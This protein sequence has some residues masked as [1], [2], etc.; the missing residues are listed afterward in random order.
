MWYAVVLHFLMPNTEQSSSTNAEVKFAP[1]SLSSLAGMPNTESHMCWLV[2]QCQVDSSILLHL[3]FQSVVPRLTG[4]APE[5]YVAMFR[6][7]ILGD[8]CHHI[9]C[10]VICEDQDIF[11]AWWL[12]QLHGCLYV[13]EV[14][15]NQF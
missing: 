15:M 13:G 7:L 11:D 1:Q 10:E 9:S 4:F 12:I 6:F 2:S 3:S 5:V 14:N 8:K